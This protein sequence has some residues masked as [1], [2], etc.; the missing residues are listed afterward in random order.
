MSEHDLI[1]KAVY[2]LTHV[3]NPLISRPGF[4][5][6]I[7]ADNGSH[8]V[9]RVFQGRIIGFDL[10]FLDDDPGLSVSSSPATTQIGDVDIVSF[11]TM[12]G[13]SI[14]GPHT[15]IVAM[16]MKSAHIYL[17]KPFLL[18]Q[19]GEF[20]ADK[21]LVYR[22]QEGIAAL[23]NEVHP[24]SHLDQLADVAS[25]GPR[26]YR[27]GSA[28]AAHWDDKFISRE[29]FSIEQSQY[30]FD[31]GRYYRRAMSP[32]FIASGQNYIWLFYIII[33]ITWL[34][35][36][37]VAFHS[38]R[39]RG[40]LGV[41]LNIVYVCL[42]VMTI[43]SFG[44]FIATWRSRRS[45]SKIYLMGI[46]ATTA[47]LTVSSG[48]IFSAAILQ[49]SDESRLRS[50]GVITLK[51]PNGLTAITFPAFRPAALPEAVEIL[52]RMSDVSLDLSGTSV[53]D[54]RPLDR[55]RSLEY[56]NLS[57]TKVDDISALSD[58]TSLK[59]LDLSGTSV[60]DIRPVGQLPNLRE[61]RWP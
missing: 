44:A 51:D 42:S 4:T 7:F 58:L 54:I 39:Q 10:V 45:F 22:A 52:R 16:L 19:I 43:T 59:A 32:N 40:D 1:T 26:N 30:G 6:P 2:H 38:F 46:L 29:Q 28:L 11:F 31:E 56:L 5:I 53:R 8:Y 23:E 14:V 12:D 18:L 47:V 20:I 57:K 36:V 15:E 55:L 3:Y 49:Q 25:D 24:A 34:A 27:Q 33:A 37:I 13:V 50:L 35:G 60:R 48:V 41:G 21:S 9:Q 61:L 17:S